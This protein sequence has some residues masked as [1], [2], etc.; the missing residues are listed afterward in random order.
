MRKYDQ[1]FVQTVC[2]IYKR[3][4]MQQFGVECDYVMKLARIAQSVEHWIWADKLSPWWM[5]LDIVSESKG[6]LSL[7]TDSCAVAVSTLAERVVSTGESRKTGYVAWPPW[8]DLVVENSVKSSTH[9]HVKKSHTFL[10][11]ALL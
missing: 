9:T 7:T 5:I 11:L 1:I 8:Y 4:V 3:K 2:R 10:I 6:H